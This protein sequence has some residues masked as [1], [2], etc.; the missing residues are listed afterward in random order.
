[1]SERTFPMYT[2]TKDMADERIRQTWRNY[3]KE[4]ATSEQRTRPNPSP[5]PENGAHHYILDGYGMKGDCK[6]CQQPFPSERI[7][8]F[9]DDTHQPM[10]SGSPERIKEAS[11]LGGQATAAKRDTSRTQARNRA[12]RR[13]AYNGMNIHELTVKY[14][15]SHSTIQHIISKSGSYGL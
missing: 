2:S 11:A 15:L 4:S 3:Q 9:E 8:F 13:L 10:P 12:I 14:G 6:Y 1:M 5:C 7:K